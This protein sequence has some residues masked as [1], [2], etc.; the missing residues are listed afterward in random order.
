MSEKFECPYCGQLY[1]GGKP[2]ELHMKYCKENPQNQ[3][4]KNNNKIE[5]EKLKEELKNVQRTENNQKTNKD[6]DQIQNLQKKLNNMEKEIKKLKK[7]QKQKNK[8]PNQ[9]YNRTILE[10]IRHY[11][12]RTIKRINKIEKEI[13]D[14]LDSLDYSN[15]SDKKK[16]KLGDPINLNSPVQLAIVIYDVLK[17]EY[18]ERTTAADALKHFRDTA[19]KGEVNLF[20][21]NM[22]KERKIS[23]LLSTYIDKL[24][25]VVKSDGKIHTRLNQVGAKT[26]R[27]SSSEP[28]CYDKETEILTD[29]GWKLFKDLDKTEKVAQWK[30]NGEIEFVKPLDYISYNYEG[31]IYKFK[32]KNTDLSVIPGHKIVSEKENGEIDYRDAETAY[33][34][35]E[36]MFDY[37]TISYKGEGDYYTHVHIY[38][39][40]YD[41][42]VYSVT[43]PSGNVVV[44]RNN[45]E[46]ISGNCQNIPSD[47]HEIRQMFKADDGKV[48][49]STDY[50]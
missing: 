1:P 3:K 37:K 26:G 12:N 31:I 34:S 49:I 14:F 22:L 36:R 19:V 41:G 29:S 39:E 2:L 28:N 46:M 10:L 45:K 35:Q 48:L 15:L 30:E 6:Q 17:L 42:F 18:E 25:E 38:K 24:P 20:F 40:I 50:S 43:V 5:N 33:L 27:F 11:N 4:K 23:K 16:S 9:E 47:N 8:P 7:S 13:H 21:D 32:G 44:R